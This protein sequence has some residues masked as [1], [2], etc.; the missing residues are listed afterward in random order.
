MKKVETKF[1][2]YI[3]M[4]TKSNSELTGDKIKV[5][6]ERLKKIGIE[7]KLT[8]N[9]PWVYID[10]ICG[11]KVKEKLY[12]NHGFTL[13]FL[14]GRLDSPPSEFTD[15][16]ETFKLIRKY[17]REALLIQMM[18]DSEKDGLYDID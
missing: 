15:I 14:P 8:G 3:D 18:R 13:I 7:V 11:I 5:F 1:G 10:E 16:P 4:E 9:Y 17:S 6:V 2:T 12:G